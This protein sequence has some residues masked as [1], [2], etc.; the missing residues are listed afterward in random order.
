M[1]KKI[2]LILIT[3][4]LLFCFAGVSY[5]RMP[6]SRL[7]RKR[8]ELFKPL[9]PNT[10]LQRAIERLRQTRDDFEKKYGTYFSFLVNYQFQD[11]LASERNEGNARNSWYY[12]I[13]IE[14]RLWEGAS[15]EVEIEGDF[16]KGIDPLLPTFA[17]LNG[18]ATA[19]SS[20]Y[21]PRYFLT[22][23]AWDERIRFSFGKID[24]SDWFDQNEV[25]SSNDTQFLSNALANNLIIPFPGKGLGCWANFKF[26]DWVYI[27]SGFSDAAAISNQP[28]FRW[29]LRNPFFINELGLTPKIGSLQGNF[30]FI[31]WINFQ[32]REFLNGEGS[33]NNDNGFGVSFDQEVLENTSLF[34]RYGYAQQKVRSVDNFWSIGGQTRGL[35]TGR[36]Y[37]VL[38]FAMTQSLTGDA[39]QKNSGYPTGSAETL[40]ETYYRF[41][42]YKTLTVTPDLQVV[43]DPAAQKK[44]KCDVVGGVRVAL[45]F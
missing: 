11:A 40:F 39:F 21:I 33:Y 1:N 8:T 7:S 44:A 34:F 35:F 37:D 16:G 28:G 19:D 12:S 24:L 29:P 32:K 10:D 27:R 42:F 4:A 14:Q 18:A 31:Y 22:Q 20:L 3:T 36:K 25:A 9:L 17:G 41:E 23:K 30:R 26:L 2:L 5:G 45:I 38:G 15:G 13:D 6:T 43:I